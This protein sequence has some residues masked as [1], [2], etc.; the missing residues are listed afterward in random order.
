MG[1]SLQIQINVSYDWLPFL[2]S[3][4]TKLKIKPVH[5][6]KTTLLKLQE[7]TRKLQTQEN[8][9]FSRLGRNKIKVNVFLGFPRKSFKSDYFP[10]FPG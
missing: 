7:C 4:F 9:Y 8:Y 10:G 2:I 1:K 5:L 6:L 3:Y